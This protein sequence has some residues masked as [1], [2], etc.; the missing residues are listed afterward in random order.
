MI[1]KICN[2]DDKDDKNDKFPFVPERALYLISA[3]TPTNEQVI[4]NWYKRS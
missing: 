1:D 4:G 2:K 3:C